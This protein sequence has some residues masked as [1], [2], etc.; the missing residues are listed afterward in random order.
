MKTFLL[1]ISF[2]ICTLKDF[3]QRVIE[4]EKYYPGGKIFARGFIIKTA[5]GPRRDTGLWTCYFPD[6]QKLSEDIRNEPLLKKY[7]N[8]WTNTG[9]QICT[10]G[11]GRFLEKGADLGFKDNCAL[12]DVDLGIWENST[13]FTIKDSIRQGPFEVYIPYK[14]GQVK[15]AEGNCINGQI[16]GEMTYFYETGQLSCKQ[17]Y[18]DNNDSGWRRKFYK[19]GKLKQEGMW[20]NGNNDSVWT[21]YDPLGNLEK[22]LT[23]V[24]GKQT[25]EVDFYANGEKKAEGDIVYV[26]PD[27]TGDMHLFAGT[28]AILTPVKNGLWMYYSN[29]GVPGKR[30]IYVNGEL[31]K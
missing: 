22:K 8:C 10:N 15:T 13:L 24:A 18:N 25:H 16:V 7:I 28:M 4:R 14:N 26:H 29:T 5:G 2:L 31:V 11:N 6:G 20:I 21:V 30:E 3:S 17:M 27:T 12:D 9:E 19:S 23:Y 1:I